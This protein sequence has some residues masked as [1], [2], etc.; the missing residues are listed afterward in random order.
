MD[1]LKKYLKDALGIETEINPLK[2]EKL[3]T[4]P[5]YITSEYS[6]QRIELYHK[7]LLL[8]FVKG[9]FTTE[10][11]R[12]HLDTIRVAFNTNTV[13]VIS[14]LEAYKRLRLIEKK[15]PFS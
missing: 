4:L 8:V 14:Q 10:R 13:A 5:V 3:K 1:D 12:K 11:L 9:N 2:A 7:D 6:I 15:I